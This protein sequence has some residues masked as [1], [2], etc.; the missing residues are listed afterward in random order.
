MRVIVAICGVMGLVWT[1]CSDVSED[2]VK[3]VFVQAGR[4]FD[5][6]DLSDRMYERAFELCE[7]DT[8]C[9]ARILADLAETNDV[10]VARSA[11]SWLGVYGKEGYL[12]FLYSCATNAAY[13]DCAVGAILN[14]EGC[15]PLSVETF[16]TFLMNTNLSQEVRSDFC[17][18]VIRKTYL[19]LNGETNRTLAMNCAIRYAAT[20]NQ[21]L[22]S[23]DRIMIYYE[24]N[25]RLSKRRL[26][27]L[28]SV[29]DLGTN[30]FQ[31]LYVTNAINELVS[32]P[33]TDLPD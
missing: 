13:A 23:L 25:Y 6:P 20:A 30:P 33:E 27:V 1:G 8:N 16:G 32:Y 14:A 22:M 7:N 5:N 4:V 12:P 31:M 24:S 26:S 17:A 19:G 3:Q 10:R 9:Y 15:T 18:D 21:N 11:I 28:R 29:R 2:T